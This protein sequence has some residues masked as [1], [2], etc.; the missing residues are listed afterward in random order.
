MTPNPKMV[1]SGE[2]LQ[3]VIKLFLEQGITSSPVINPVGEILG[4]LTELGLVKAY[5]LHKLKLMKND[6]VGHHIDLLEPISYI[7]INTPVADALRAM[8]ASPTHRLLVRDE[9]NKVVGIIS[10][11]DL[12]RGML[13]EANPMQNIRQ[14]LKETENMLRESLSILKNLKENLKVYRTVFH[15]TPYMMHAVDRDG[16]ILMA[17]K[18][19]HETLGYPDGALIGKTIFDIYSPS[20]HDEARKGL[21][22]VIKTG[23]QNVIYTSL[24]K[25]DGST[26]RCDIVSSAIVDNN[27]NFVSTISALRPV[28]SEE[29][30]RSLHGIVSDS[31]YV[32]KS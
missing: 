10:P 28:D 6:R 31:R 14:K 22:Q 26:I 3:D 18:R 2:G 27:G 20:M 4:A 1:G 25:K 17:N 5:M 13:G 8:L 7:D 23:H 9:K 24:V 12:M 16:K 21:E 32:N 30:L 11:K 29:L 15:E 19:E